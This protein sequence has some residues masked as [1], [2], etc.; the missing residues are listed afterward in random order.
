MR[1]KREKCVINS[2]GVQVARSKC[3]LKGVMVGVFI[4]IVGTECIIGMVEFELLRQ[5][6]RAIHGN[7]MGSTINDV[8][9]NDS[10]LHSIVCT[11]SW[12]NHPHSHVFVCSITDFVEPVNHSAGIHFASVLE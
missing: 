5:K 12:M 11:L 6:F 9:M 7:K 10:V 8:N 4:D 1:I 2:N 3:N